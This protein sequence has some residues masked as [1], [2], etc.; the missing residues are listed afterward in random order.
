MAKFVH[1]S[2]MKF[3]LFTIPQNVFPNY[4]KKFLVQRLSLPI[5]MHIGPRNRFSAF[6][7]KT[8]RLKTKIAR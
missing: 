2:Q 3:Y 8:K 5:V 6:F 1:G 4:R 7:S